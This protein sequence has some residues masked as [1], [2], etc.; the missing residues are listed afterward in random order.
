MISNLKEISPFQ[1][2][3]NIEKI[4]IDNAFQN[5]YYDKAQKKL[6]IFSIFS[7]KKLENSSLSNILTNDE[8]ETIKQIT[9][10]IDKRNKISF[11]QTNYNSHFE[12]LKKNILSN[13]NNNNNSECDSDSVDSLI[14][15]NFDNNI[16]YDLSN[17][18]KK[19]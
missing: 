3:P 19:K 11:S 6:L 15:L 4:P 18:K 9:D 2:F 13:N 1:Q 17:S 5:V 10:K 16:E 8:I 14:T 7:K 12:N